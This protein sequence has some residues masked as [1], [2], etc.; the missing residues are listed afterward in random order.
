MDNKKERLKRS[1]EIAD[2]VKNGE[3]VEP[4]IDTMESWFPRR[5]PIKKD[6]EAIKKLYKDTGD[7]NGKS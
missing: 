3:Y 4:A 2:R 7:G 1:Q 5:P 6:K